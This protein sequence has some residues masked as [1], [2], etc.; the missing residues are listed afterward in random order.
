MYGLRVNSLIFSPFIQSLLV[1]WVVC[2]EMSSAVFEFALEFGLSSG[3]STL[4]LR[5]EQDGF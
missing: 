4:D 2:L 5:I 1:C 3:K